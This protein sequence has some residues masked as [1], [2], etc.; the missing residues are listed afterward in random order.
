MSESKGI[1]DFGDVIREAILQL[2]ES[3]SFLLQVIDLFKVRGKFAL[4]YVYEDRFLLRK[5]KI[6]LV[7]HW[8]LILLQVSFPD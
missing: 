1:E 8:R 5:G 4:P 7:T 2:T 3:G 6:L